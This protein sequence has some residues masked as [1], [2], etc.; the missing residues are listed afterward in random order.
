VLSVE[1]EQDF[2]PIQ[3]PEPWAAQ[4]TVLDL[5]PAEIEKIQYLLRGQ[6]IPNP[7]RNHSGRS[8]STDS[9]EDLIQRRQ[10]EDWAYTRYTAR[11]IKTIQRRHASLCNTFTEAVDFLAQHFDSM[12][13]WP[14]LM[15]TK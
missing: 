4:S 10:L 15:G 1:W 11:A 2:E 6:R 3:Y 8:P 12:I 9:P 5:E 13:Q 7:R 14:C